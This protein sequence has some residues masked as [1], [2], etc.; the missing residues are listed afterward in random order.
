MKQEVQ[1]LTIRPAT[2]ADLPAI[3]EI[4]NEAIVNSTATADEDPQNLEQRAD[5][6]RARQE[7][8]Y[9]VFVAEGAG[10]VIGWSALSAFRPHSGYRFTAE[11][12]VYIAAGH[13]GRGIGARL[14]AAL[15]DAARSRGLHTLVSVIDGSNMA[16]VRLHRRFGFQLAGNVR[17]AYHKFGRWH[18]AV[19][20]QLLLDPEE[21]GPGPAYGQVGDR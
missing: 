16:S 11:V 4:Y 14:L 18:D 13:R 19:Y 15:I 3:L 17:Q 9:P 8:G 10:A 20:L 7:A 2:E 21:P 6:F 12:S 5:W 1:D